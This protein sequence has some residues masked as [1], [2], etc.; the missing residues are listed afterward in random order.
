LLKEYR[1]Y[2]FLDNRDF[3]NESFMVMVQN[4]IEIKNTIQTILKEIKNYYG[5]N[6]FYSKMYYKLIKDEDKE[7]LIE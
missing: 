1:K 7:S 4:L 5:L 3:S 6:N 2:Y